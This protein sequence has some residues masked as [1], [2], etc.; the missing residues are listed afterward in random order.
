MDY[1]DQVKTSFESIEEQYRNVP[2]REQRFN[3][4]II[5]LNK[6]LEFCRTGDAKLPQIKEAADFLSN[7]LSLTKT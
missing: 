1:I 7:K 2:N 4:E 5:E 6:F 3:S